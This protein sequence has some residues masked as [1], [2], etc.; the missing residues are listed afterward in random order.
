MRKSRGWIF[1]TVMAAPKIS[2]SAN[3]ITDWDEKVV[4][5][6]QTRMSAPPGH[7]VMATLHLAM[8]D[9]VNSIAPRYKPYKTTIATPPETSKEAAR[10]VH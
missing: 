5:T 1:L 4:A 2:A 10:P 8:F 3:V 6:G 7:R 9:A